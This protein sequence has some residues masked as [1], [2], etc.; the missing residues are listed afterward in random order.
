MIETALAPSNPRR[1][2]TYIRVA[3]TR[4]R[5]RG[6]ANLRVLDTKRL[7]LAGQSSLQYKTAMVSV[8]TL[9]SILYDQKHSH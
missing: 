8:T 3:S 9:A 6:T 4:T 5:K 1:S 2:T 7:R